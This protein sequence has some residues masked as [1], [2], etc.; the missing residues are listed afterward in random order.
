MLLAEIVRMWGIWGKWGLLEKCEENADFKGKCGQSTSPPILCH[1]PMKKRLYLVELGWEWSFYCE[2][3]NNVRLHNNVRV[4]KGTIY[5]IH[6]INRNLR[7]KCDWYLIISFHEY[8]KVQ[9]TGCNYT[10]CVM[11]QINL[12]NCGWLE[13]PHRHC[14]IGTLGIQYIVMGQLCTET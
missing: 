9:Y 7:L 4:Y 11:L 3:I 14:R 13:H 8:T 12:H 1:N 5:K 6:Y 10:I 2:I